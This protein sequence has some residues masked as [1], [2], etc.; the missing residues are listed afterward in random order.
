MWGR[1]CILLFTLLAAARICFAIHPDPGNSTPERFNS[2]PQT[3]TSERN[4]RLYDSIQ[5][6]SNRRAVPRMLYKMLFTRP[7]LDTTFSG[8][9]LD[10]SRLL[11]PYEGKTIGEICVERL[12]VFGSDGNWF[13]RTGNNLHVQTRDQVIRRDLLVKSGERL[14]PQLVVRNRQ[15][16]RSRPYISDAEI[17][18]LPDSLDSTQVNLIV[19]TRDSW[20]IS[21]DAGLHSGGRTM[22]GVSDANILGTGNRL[23]IKTNFNR[24]NFDYGGN[25]VEYQIP[26][27]LGTF[28]TADFSAGRD[29]YNS[30]LKVGLYKEFIRPT[31][32]EIGLTY[33]DVKSKYYMVNLDTSNL[34]KQRTIDTWAGRS[35]YFKGLN[36]SFY[37]TGRYTYSRFSM[38]PEVGE[39]HNPVFH[40][41]DR[42]L[43]G[44]GF[45]R[46]KFFA[47]NMIYGFGVKEYLAT[48][49]K[50][51]IVGGY[52]WGEFDDEM[53]I[54]TSYRV[55]GFNA[56]GYMMGSFT[57]GSYIDLDNGA[58][59][60]SGVDI[61][62]RWFSNLFL[63]RRNHIRQFF[64]L[65]Y[66]QGWNRWSG[67]DETLRFT[68]H[69]RPQALKEYITGTNRMVVNTETVIFTPFQPLGFRFAF[70]G[71][72]DIGLI[73]YSPNIFKND[74]FA[75]FGLGV[76]IKNER[77]IFS[78]IQLRLGLAFGKHGLVDTDYFN[79]SNGT[80][81]EQ[82]RYR[83]T[84][85]ETVRFE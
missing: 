53:Y 79:V 35:R 57:L 33:S 31:D 25:I 6:K 54:G 55:G 13:E 61:D 60:R 45:Y 85:P 58:W 2:G 29:F 26:N 43:L 39:R 74:F 56:M 82:Y 50:A 32:Y 18:V 81:L 37:F 12:P 64:A 47:A 78:A 16:L 3:P 66:T 11:R 34:I 62:L 9:V 77:L 46:E 24:E 83:P 44:A 28:Y 20:T 71:F 15:L 36:S 70:F 65:N 40:G 75:S 73:G 72:A 7:Q 41:Y 49:Y 38:R 17:I 4:Q 23:N 63:F 27:V 8:Q 67:C 19:R 84:R 21:A 52:S 30:E 48:G 42:M 22:I 69:N 51:E 1:I 5:S 68:K 10:E 76:R 14:D 80:R 59:Y